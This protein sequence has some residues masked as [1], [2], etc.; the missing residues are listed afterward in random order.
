MFILFEQGAK[1]QELPFSCTIPESGRQ[2]ATSLMD[3]SVSE[4]YT[5]L[6]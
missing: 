2:R 6:F 1:L 5:K 3:S 4:Y